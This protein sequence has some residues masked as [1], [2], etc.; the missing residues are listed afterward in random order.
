MRTCATIVSAP[1]ATSAQSRLGY[2]ALRAVNRRW[3]RAQLPSIAFLSYV[4][5][6]PDTK[7]SKRLRRSMHAPTF[8]RKRDR[9]LGPAPRVVHMA[10][11]KVGVWASDILVPDRPT[12]LMVGRPGRRM[13]DAQT[14]AFQVRCKPHME[15]DLDMYRS[16]FRGWRLHRW[17]SSAKAKS[18]A[19]S[20]G[21]G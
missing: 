11:K 16:P 5:F 3:D 6:Y 13:S 10:V 9:Y 17:P 2:F 21:G 12:G 18:L 15:L 8:L 19:N 20:G 4:V 7:V 14:P 1:K